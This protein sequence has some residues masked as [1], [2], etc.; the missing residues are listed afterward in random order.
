MTTDVYMR[1]IAPSIQSTI[2]SINSELREWDERSRKKSATAGPNQISR[3]QSAQAFF[4]HD[5]K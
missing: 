4:A 5:T 3:C 1:E 2:N